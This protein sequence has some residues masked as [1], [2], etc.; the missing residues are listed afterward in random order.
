ML[1]AAKL[2]HSRFTFSSLEAQSVKVNKPVPA[3][4]KLQFVLPPT[5]CSVPSCR[6]ANS[7][8]DRANA[9]VYTL[10]EQFKHFETPSALWWV[11]CRAKV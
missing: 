3:W 1:I 5:P 2:A 9:T 10:S 4:S 6:G 7:P 11:I 8:Y